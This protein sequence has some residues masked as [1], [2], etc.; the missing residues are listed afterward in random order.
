[1]TPVFVLREATVE[2]WR[3]ECVA[4]GIDPTKPQPWR[5]YYDVS[6]D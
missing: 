5:F 1:M 4:E 2:E 6:V 3:L